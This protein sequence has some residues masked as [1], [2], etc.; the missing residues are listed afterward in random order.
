MGFAFSQGKLDTTIDRDAMLAHVAAIAA[1]TPLPVSAELENGYG[2]SPEAVAATIRLAA[3]AGAV[4][5]SIE[6]ATG[7]PDDPI[8]ERGLAVERVRAAVAAARALPF[9]FTLTARAENFLHGRS[10]LADTLERLQAF[11]DVGADVLYAPG[12][13][14]SDDLATV[15]TSLSRPVNVLMGLQGVVLSRAEL[16]ALGARRISVGS[17][18]YRAAMGAF[19]RAATEMRDAGT[20]GFAAAA[21]SPRDLADIFRDR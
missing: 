6:D 16:S 14:T 7:R 5:G 13:R 20:F 3:A 1:A 8:Y 11:E 9:P 2:D 12:L 21:A 15:V 17:S 19:V 18:L 4:G 10:D